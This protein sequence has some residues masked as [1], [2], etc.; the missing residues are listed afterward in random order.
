MPSFDTSPVNAYLISVFSL[1]VIAVVLAIGV[2]GY[3]LACHRR[4]RP[5]RAGSGAARFSRARA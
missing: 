4:L 1:A 3:A 5:S 2:I